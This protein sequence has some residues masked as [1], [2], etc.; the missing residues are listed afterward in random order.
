[1][2]HCGTLKAESLNYQA[3]RKRLIAEVP[4]LDEETLADT[5]EGITNLHE[6]I[7][8]VLRSALEDQAMAK[9]LKGRIEEMKERLDRLEARAKK[10][11]QLALDAMSEAKLRK[12]TEPDFTASVRRGQPSLNVVAE[13]DI[14]EGYWVPQPPRLDR[15]ALTAALKIGEVVPGAIL[16]APN[17]TLTVRTK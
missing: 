2:R 3:L 14:P 6:M 7:A 17:P 1:M 8:E 13:A 11:K 16:N 15:A 10:K 4:G 5:L 9:G 12:L